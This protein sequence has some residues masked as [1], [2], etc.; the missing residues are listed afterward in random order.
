MTDSYMPTQPIGPGRTI[1]EASAG[2]GKT[3]TIAALVAHLVAAEGVPIDRILVITFTR[4]ATAELRGRIRRRLVETLAAAEAGSGDGDEHLRAVFEVA[5]PVEVQ[6]RVRAALSGFDRAQ[7]F[8]IHGFAQRLLAALGFGSRLPADLEPT[9]LDARMLAVAASDLA[10]GR[11]AADGDSRDRLDPSDLVAIGREVVSKPDARI[12]PDVSEVTGKHRSRVEMA[13]GIRAEMNRRLRKEGLVSYD[14][15]LAELSDV[16]SD[17]EVG[18]AAHALLAARYEI[19]LVDEAQDTDPLQWRVIRAMFE[20]SRLVVIGDPKQSIYRFRGAD[21]DAYLDA[22]RDARVL[23]LGTNWRSDGRLL[24]ALDALF[25]GF[26]FGDDAIAYHRVQP[27]DGHTGTRIE[28]VE[29]AMSIRWLTSDLPIETRRSDPSVFLIDP[30]RRAVAADAAAHIVDLLESDVEIEGRPL[31]PSDIAVLCRTSRQADMVRAELDRR[32]VPSVSGRSGAVFCSEAA[33]D[34]RRFLMGVE[35]PERMDL[36]RLGATTVL[37]GMSLHDIA[38]LDDEREVSLQ[39]EMRGLQRLLHEAGVPRLLAE[40]DR[41]RHL[42]ERVLERPNGER[43]MTDLTHIAEELHHAWRPGRLGSLVAWLEDA[44][45]ESSQRADDGGEEP[46]ARQRRL[47]TDAEAVQVLTIHA[48][49]GLEWPVV[50]A[51]FGW[52]V[53]DRSPEIPVLH[54]D[55]SGGRIIDVAGEG[56]WRGFEANAGA[57]RA[58][59][60]AEE[61]RLLYVALT[62]ARHHLVVWWVSQTKD[63][64]NSTLG[65]VL[66]RDSWKEAARAAGPGVIAKPA[67]R[68]LAE[69]RPYGA[70][71]RSTANLA[72]ARFERQLD[73][74]WRRASFSSLSPEHPL[75]DETAELKADDELAPDDETAPP[76]DLPMA[77]LPKGARFGT[78]VH[79]MFESVEFDDPDLAASLRAVLTPA[80]E[81]SGWDFDADAFVTGMVGAITT[82]LGPDPDAPA[83]AGVGRVLKE[84]VFELPV[85]A[86]VSLADLGAVMA[87]HLEAGDP[88]VAYVDRLAALNAQRFRGF[89]TGAIDLTLAL[90]DGR[91]VVMDYKSNALSDYAAATI[92]DAMIDGNYVL[93][94]TFYQVALHRYLSWRLPGYNPATNLGGSIYLFLRGAIGPDTP[95]IDGARQGVNVW[96]PAPA[97]I[98]AISELFAGSQPPTGHEG[99]LS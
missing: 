8:T 70:T 94:S 96:T 55:A 14:D 74:L 56:G 18:G 54:D 75:T 22:A 46:E 28:G 97:M 43:V 24:E 67:V 92:A 91:W 51:P 81:R 47:E 76:P 10:V 45:R 31:Q 68:Q 65:K 38:E 16:L 39:L 30:V 33:E 12:V 79:E 11:W 20:Q 77:D 21:I 26:A 23:T 49:K 64:A 66:A 83:L 89:L 48:A 4:A 34:W 25:A 42:T 9:G 1:I 80:M 72:A 44:M 78:L 85:P 52:D 53:W 58:E 17:P 73:H 71:H 62:R 99:T 63:A 32:R 7:I 35:H 2:T 88:F 5:T 82:P 60:K 90:D 6:R 61:S 19:G 29:A 13:E 95:V 27:A 50:L 40:V 15:G 3:H 41:T 84:L 98:V 37:M 57:A 86:T 93:Q 69:V 59:E 87:A 36:V